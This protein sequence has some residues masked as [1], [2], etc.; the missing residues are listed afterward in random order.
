MLPLA[1]TG[2]QLLPNHGRGKDV[3]RG[4]CR[5]PEVYG[6]TLLVWAVDALGW[7]DETKQPNVFVWHPETVRLELEKAAGVGLPDHNFDKL[8]ACVAVMTTDAFFKDPGRFIILVNALVGEG[9]DPHQVD[10]PSSL[11]IAWAVTEAL[12]L[13]P[14]D[15]KEPEPFSTEVRHYVGRVLREE[16]YV[17][18]PDILRIALDADF[19]AKVTYDFGDDPEMFGAITKVQEDKSREV[20]AVV[21]EGLAELL[22]QLKAL[23]LQTGNTAEVEKRIGQTLRSTT[24]AAEG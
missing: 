4:L 23:P 12:L 10:H 2:T 9:F 11:E 18:P 16:G 3:L 19:S 13:V 20:T 24:H 8:M 5:D 22:G 14:P 17:T 15:A 1:N 7:D 6:T 21:S